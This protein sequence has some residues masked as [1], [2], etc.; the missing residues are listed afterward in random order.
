MDNIR[1]LPPSSLTNEQNEQIPPDHER[2]RLL[3]FVRTPTNK[4][5]KTTPAPRQRWTDLA[6]ERPSWA[7]APP[8]QRCVIAGCEQAIVKGDLVYCADHRTR[9]DDGTL[10]LRCVNHPDRP[11]APHDPIA[12]SECRLLIDAEPMPWEMA[13]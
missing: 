11:V 5:N 3:E 12:C 9:A 6:V 13:R 2:G 7:P 10:W 8:G 4:T 1:I